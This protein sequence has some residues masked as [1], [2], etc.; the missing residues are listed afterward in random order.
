[1]NT[2]YNHYDALGQPIQIGDLVVLSESGTAYLSKGTVVKF[3]PKNVT[4]NRNYVGSQF[5]GIV[6]KPPKT[7]VVVT[8]QHEHATTTWPELFA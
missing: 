6:T 3:T 8:K 7:M 1:M 2:P 5:T 4:V